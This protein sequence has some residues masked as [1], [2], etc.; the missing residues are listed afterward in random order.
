MS[1]KVSA[2]TG[3]FDDTTGALK[4]ISRDCGGAST[5]TPTPIA[6]LSAAQQSAIDA[7]GSSV[8]V[9]ASGVLVDK[10]LSPVSGGGIRPLVGFIGDSIAA[11]LGSDA[12]LLGKQKI[13]SNS[14]AGYAAMLSD[15]RWDLVIN[16]GVGGNSSD[17]IL[18]RIATEIIP[19]GV[20]I[21]VILACFFNSVGA[22]GQTWQQTSVVI[23]N[24][25]KLLVSAGITPVLSLPTPYG[26]SGMSAG[27]NTYLSGIA[28]WLRVFSADNSFKLIDPFSTTCDP[29]TGLLA[30]QYN[31]DGSVH[32]NAAF[33]KE[34][35]R[36]AQIVLDGFIP[37]GPSNLIKYAT[38]TTDILNGFGMLWPDSN[39]DGTPDG[40]A[41]SIASG[42]TVSIVTDS[43]VPGKMLKFSSVGASGASYLDK[44]LSSGWSVNDWLE[45]SGVCTATG[46]AAWP[47]FRLL[48]TAPDGSNYPMF[49]PTAQITRGKFRLV[50]Q[51]PTGTTGLSMRFQI[52]PGTGDMAF[53]QLSIRNM[54]VLGTLRP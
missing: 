1:N 5:G 46:G 9:N 36:C 6:A 35:G 19:S 53:G 47:R 2:I 13:I 8:V 12:Y 23:Q 18:T 31:V 39:S 37:A 44:S 26:T 50:W 24:M 10:N 45:I 51:V 21:C 41:G 4:S 22:A 52:M 43:A 34:L 25:C 38:D 54:S 14:P 16:A 15:G 20:K 27:V 40:C 42:T 3:V 17:Q 28:Q 33:F 7:G 11:S 29:M 30:A 49:E 48:V 32:G